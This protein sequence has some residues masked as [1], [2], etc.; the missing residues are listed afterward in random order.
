LKLHLGSSNFDFRDPRQVAQLA[1]EFEAA[2]KAH[3][4]IVIHMQTRSP[5]YGAADVKTLL[6]RI[7]P[8]AG[9]VPVQIAHA[10]GGGGI[11]PGQLAALRTFADAMAR[12][13]ES[14][15]HLYFDLAMVPDLFANDGKVAAKPRDVAVL[16][17]LMRR[18]GLNRF[19]AW[20]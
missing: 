2:G 10:G 8:R 17:D 6:K 13:P 5:D 16:D 3:L 18:I 7:Y 9:D 15:R 4:A 12:D 14:T 19:S 11:D 20:F 1:A